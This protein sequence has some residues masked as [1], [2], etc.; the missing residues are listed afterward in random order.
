MP[1][2]P[3][4]QGDRR[5]ELLRIT[6]E[7]IGEVG[8]AAMSV[9]EVARRAGVTHAALTYH[10]GDKIGLLTA[11]AIDG[12]RLLGDALRPALT[13]HRSFA[14]IGVAYVRF[15]VTHP[16]HVEVMFQPRL[17]HADDHDLLAAKQA[18]TTLLCG[19]AEATTEQLAAGVTAWSIVHGVS[20]LFINGNLPP[21]LG[22]DP[23]EITRLVA[24]HLGRARHPRQSPPERPTF[25]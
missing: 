10:F 1:S 24:A 21:Q 11:V 23:E 19:C 18:T 17:H 3:P 8:A 22:D 13:E 2:S 4:H 15:A 25:Q 6:I 20:T 16:A 5:D 9:R 7:A 14:E 12:Y